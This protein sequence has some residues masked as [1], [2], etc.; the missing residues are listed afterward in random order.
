MAVKIAYFLILGQ[1]LILYLGLLTL[2]SF[3][4]TAYIGLS[5]YK[6]WHHWPIKYHYR[7]VK[8]SFALAIIHGTLGLLTHFRF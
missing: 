3:L 7:M 6:G 4:I 8:V 1:P 2:T 5:L